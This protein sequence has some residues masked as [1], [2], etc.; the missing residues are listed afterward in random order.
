M[1]SS[2]VLIV[3]AG[4]TG[5]T[6]AC[7]L[8]RSGAAVRIIDKSPSFHRTSRA[9]GPN[10]RSREI[11]ADLGVGE[12]LDAAG[13][14][15]MVLR[16]YR[17]GVALHD[18][19]INAGPPPGPGVPYP[20][21]LGIPQWKVE[22]ILRE[23][24]ASYGVRVELG[25]ELAGLAQDREGVL[26]TLADGRRIEAGYAVGC[27]GGHS[28]V[29]KALGVGF[30]GSSGPE[31][32]MWCG[33]VE[34]DGLD[35]GYW[36]QW[37]DEDGAMLL[38]PIPGTTSWQLQSSL[39][40]DEA[41]RPMAP[42]M[43]GFQRLFDRHAR[44]PG[45]R[46]AN[47]TWLSTYRVSVRMA[48]RFREGRVFLAGDAAHVQP[49]AGGL[50][51]NTGIQDAFNLGWKLALVA[52]G[53]AGEALLDTYDEERRPVAAWTLKLTGER[54]RAALEGTRTAGVG[55]EVVLT[56][57]TTT[58]GVGY[59][60]SSLAWGGR[61]A[62]ERAPDGTG[63]DGRLFGLFAG[64]HF[65]LLGFGAGSAPALAEVAGRFPELVRAHRADG[66]GA[67]YGVEGE[68]LV[69]VRPDH[70]IALSTGADRGAEVVDRLRHLGR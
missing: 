27:D 45:V 23:K 26:V 5:L 46:L 7:T 59:G 36:H 18:A 33:D 39:E 60:W 34:A 30:E 64:P 49:I 56:E 19:D 52:R 48:E 28:P 42:S 43:A 61:G 2:T 16:K 37:F 66:A 13:S 24:L 65:T 63:A 70:H 62:G 69:L 11:F 35:R 10:Q 57:D 68:G 12:A 53:E 20:T 50:G 51:M 22:E 6:L 55:T 3:G 29:R 17:G 9:K 40:R 41:G 54:L 38:W 1:T 15:R 21:G 4:P 25:C 31:E 67:A 47:P 32:V 14:T 8:A 44:V 58:L